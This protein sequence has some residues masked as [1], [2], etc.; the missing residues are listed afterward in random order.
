MMHMPNGKLQIFT[1]QVQAALAQGGGHVHLEQVRD[2][3]GNL[4]G[5]KDLDQARDGP[6]KRSSKKKPTIISSNSS[7]PKMTAAE[8]NHQKILNEN[9]NFKCEF[10]EQ[11]F[12]LEEH[13]Q[14]HIKR[15]HT[16]SK[17]E[18]DD[19]VAQIP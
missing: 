18:A 11:L 17:T 1:P 9:R 3:Q 13:L 14:M 6:K 10:C 2:K 19:D 15:I 8:E 16:E 5:F 7:S 12:S 4:L